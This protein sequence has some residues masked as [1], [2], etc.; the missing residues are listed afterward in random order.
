MHKKRTYQID[1]KVKKLGGRPRSKRAQL[2]DGQAL[3]DI[4][5]STSQV[6]ERP[7]TLTHGLHVYSHRDWLSEKK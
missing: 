2:P 6:R 7:V 3:R 1:L 5:G 4:S